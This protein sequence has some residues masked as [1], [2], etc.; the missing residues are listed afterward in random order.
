VSGRL[1]RL[2]E[3]GLEHLQL[4]GLDRCPRAASLTFMPIYKFLVIKK[5]SVHC[6]S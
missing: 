6:A 1:G 3:G 2:V 5:T 4:F